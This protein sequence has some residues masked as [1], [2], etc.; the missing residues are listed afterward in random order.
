MQFISQLDLADFED[1]KSTHD[2]RVGILIRVDCY[3]N[4]LL[5]KTLQTL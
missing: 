5:G 3:F 1:N 2:S 4:Y